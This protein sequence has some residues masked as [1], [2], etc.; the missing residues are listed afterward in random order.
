MSDPPSTVPPQS[1]SLVGFRSRRREW[2][3]VAVLRLIGVVDGSAA[4]AILLP[5][6]AMDVV[7]RALALGA[8]PD[9][10]IVDYLARSLS[11]LYVFRGVMYL[12]ASGDVRERRGLIAV[13]AWSSVLMGPALLAIDLAAGLPASW[14]WS[15]W[16]L[17]M[18]PGLLLLTL[19][20]RQP[21]VVDNPSGIR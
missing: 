9:A 13:L 21:S 5:R 4:L 20:G 15:E 11:L 3:L 17:V 19:L 7:H 2:L 8:L 12:Y 6:E 18:L 16:L 14:T 10:A 1:G